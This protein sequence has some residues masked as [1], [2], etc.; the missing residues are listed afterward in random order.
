MLPSQFVFSL[1]G[2]S[3]VIISMLLYV[4]TG[5]KNFWELQR[6]DRKSMFMP[7]NK[8]LQ[9]ILQSI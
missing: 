1:Y 6:F 4:D 9:N 8:I 3:W 7:K 2:L 5:D